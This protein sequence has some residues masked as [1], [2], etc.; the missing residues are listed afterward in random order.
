M[1]V[2]FGVSN[3]SFVWATKTVIGRMDPGGSGVGARV[4]V[5]S[6]STNGVGG[7]K[8]TAPKRWMSGLKERMEAR[9]SEVLDPWLPA[10][11][12]KVGWRQILGGLFFFPALVAIRGFVGYASS[13]CLGWVSE[14][15]VNDLRVDVLRTLSRLSL[16]FFNR[17][18]MGDLITHVNGD[19]AALQ[20]SLS[21]GVSDLVK[22]PVTI[23]GMIGML[24]L[25]DWQM[26]L[27]AMVFFPVCVVPIIV[28]GKKVRKASKAGLN[29]NI[30]QSSLLVEMLSGIRVVKAFGLEENQVN[31]FR[32]LSA[33]LVHHG[34][35]GIRAKEMIN[36]I[37]ETVSMVG[38]GLLIVYI[39]ARGRAVSE[40]VAFLTGLIFFYTPVKKLAGLHVLFEQT[41]AGVQ[42]LIQILSEQPSVVEAKDPIRVKGF[43][44]GLRLDNLRFAYAGREV[45]HGVDLDIP[46]GA[47]VG[48]A[49][50][51]GSGKSTLVNL[52]FRF[53]D[54]TAGAIL[55]DGHDLRSIE[56][57]GLRDQMALVSQ[58]IVLFDLSVAENIGCGKPG[59]TR[60]E[61]VA[62]A[63]AAHA[64][65]FIEQLP[66]GY[67]TRVGERGVT[68]SGGQRQRLAI[69][70]AFVRNAPILVLDEATASLDSQSEAEVQ[71]AIEGLSRNRTVITVAHRLSTLATSSVIVVLNQG[72]VVETGG[73]EELLSRNG[74]FAAM[75]RRQGITAG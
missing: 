3:A 61:I 64:H 45:L 54:P 23:L 2:L 75:A 11:G 4:E 28:L 56:L 36:P 62:A 19:T 74:W 42:R 67:D 24:C 44:R 34:M 59:A 25:I 26:T 31:R 27:G 68:L 60:E 33:E 17:S 30:T 14:R 6:S 21:L 73:Y 69:A 16:D 12:K 49:G 39:A 29:V 72:R 37:I 5:P 71:S 1:G 46:R 20:R 15:V 13:Y 22:E 41:S 10:F 7:G 58:E 51:S 50:E 32:K 65:E 48:I 35:K 8:V 63:R 70:R 53:Y 47:R 57:R 43:E 66:E 9:T 55:I 18:T 38:F 52:L 40:M